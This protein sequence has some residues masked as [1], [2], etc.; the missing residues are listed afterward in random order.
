MGATATKKTAAQHD[1]KNERDELA[2]VNVSVICGACSGPPEIRVLE[3]GTRLATLAL[4]CPTGDDRATSVPVTVWDPPAWLD[5][6]EAGDRLVVVGKLRRR[7]FQRPG[8]VGSRVDVE[9]ELVG[10]ARDRRR[11]DAAVRKAQR[12]LDALSEGST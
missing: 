4:R 2:S 7:F 12:E 11:I 8:G 10:R 1:D 6:V 3:S 9:A 5:T